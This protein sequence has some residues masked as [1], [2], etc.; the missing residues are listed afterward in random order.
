MWRQVLFSKRVTSADGITR[1]GLQ[2]LTEEKAGDVECIRRISER[3]GITEKR[4]VAFIHN[5]GHKL[6]VG[7]DGLV[8]ELLGEDHPCAYEIQHFRT[9]PQ[10]GRGIPFIHGYCAPKNEKVPAL[11]ELVPKQRQDLDQ[12]LQQVNGEGA[13]A[14]KPLR[15][16]PVTFSGPRV[17]GSAWESIASEFESGKHVG[18]TASFTTDG[19][20]FRWLEPEVGTFVEK[21]A[22]S[23][24][25][26]KKT[27]SSQAPGRIAFL[28]LAL[29]SLGALAAG[30]LVREIVRRLQKHNQTNEREK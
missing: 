22:E 15:V 24:A 21:V 17:A 1:E 19:R 3:E 29:V 13:V 25:S 18:R 12:I 27:P 26:Q 8:P 14:S 7:V 28:P 30:W 23:G 10:K 2:L 9:G 6:W 4:S 11:E 16:S 5:D 20:L